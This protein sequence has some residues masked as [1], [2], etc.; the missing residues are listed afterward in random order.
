MRRCVICAYTL[1]LF[2]H[3]G[4]HMLKLLQDQHFKLWFMS[5]ETLLKFG[6]SQSVINHS[7]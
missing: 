2:S 7:H 6:G 3:A 5:H 4:S 1:A